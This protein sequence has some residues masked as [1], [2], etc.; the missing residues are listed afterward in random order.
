MLMM[1]SGAWAADAH[2]ARLFGAADDH[3]VCPLDL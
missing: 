3:D 1:L 2:D